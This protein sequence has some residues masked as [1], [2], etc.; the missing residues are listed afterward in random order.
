VSPNIILPEDW[1]IEL[2]AALDGANPVVLAESMRGPDMAIEATLV[3]K[4]FAAN[5]AIVTRGVI[6][7]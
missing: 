1:F 3:I 5:P 7:L 6:V 4:T 2:A